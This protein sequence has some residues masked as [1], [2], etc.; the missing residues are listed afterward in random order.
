MYQYI[1][2]PV[3]NQNF[4]LNSSYEKNILK[5]YFKMLIQRSKGGKSNSA[6]HAPLKKEDPPHAV[7]SPEMR[8]IEI[9]LEQAKSTLK[10]RKNQLSDLELTLKKKEEELKV[11]T[12][13]RTSGSTN[14]ENAKQTLKQ[15]GKLKN[16]VS[17]CKIKLSDTNQRISSLNI[18]IEQLQNQLYELHQQG[19]QQNKTSVNTT[20]V[21]KIS[22]EKF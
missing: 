6:P 16:E 13:K 4:Y 12:E 3:R 8:S 15:E 10:K 9:Q 19:K 17:E 14:K 11:E 22:D 1:Y 21:N 18:T 5:N 20:S 7:A 2:C